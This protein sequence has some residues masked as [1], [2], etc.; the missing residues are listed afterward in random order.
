MAAALSWP[1]SSTLLWP[2]MQTATDSKHHAQ[3]FF[4]ISSSFTK[5]N[6]RTFCK[7]APTLY[8]N[9]GQYNVKTL[10]MYHITPT[11]HCV[12]EFFSC[13]SPCCGTAVKLHRYRWPHSEHYTPHLPLQACYMKCPFRQLALSSST[14]CIEHTHTAKRCTSSQFSPSLVCF[15]C[16]FI[17]FFQVGVNL[18]SLLECFYFENVK[19]VVQRHFNVSEERDTTHLVRQLN[20]SKCLLTLGF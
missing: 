5:C 2:Q 3:A 11:V 12:V 20:Q 18:F 14:L 9:K 15:Y 13:V 10:R 4:F 7:L 17:V 1:E 19:V 8:D 6:Y 16:I